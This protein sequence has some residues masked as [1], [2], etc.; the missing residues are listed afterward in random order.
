M[1]Q[2][3]HTAWLMPPPLPK[4]AEFINYTQPAKTNYSNVP[5]LW[6]YKHN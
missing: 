1:E 3:S 6:V 2:L 5:Y 4:D